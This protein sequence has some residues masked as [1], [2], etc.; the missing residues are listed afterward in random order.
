MSA[1]FAAVYHHLEPWLDLRHEN[2]GRKT[3]RPNLRR[4]PARERH[5]VLG[6]DLQACVLVRL[7]VGRQA[8]GVQLVDTD[9][10][11]RLDAPAR[12]D[13][14]PAVKGQLARP[15]DQQHLETTCAV[16]GQQH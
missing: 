11:A 9:E 6:V 7:T 8:R 15:L 16:A 1:Y 5:Y 10:V 3:A 4:R 13:P 14:G 2:P 12:E